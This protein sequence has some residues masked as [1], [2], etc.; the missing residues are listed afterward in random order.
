MP[1]A[2]AHS[3]SE[4]STKLK[5]KNADQ[6]DDEQSE[7]EYEI[8]EVMDA[9]RGVFPDGQMGYF[10][11]WK[12]Y[13]PDENS[14]VVEGDAENAKDLVDEFWRKNPAKRRD[15]RKSVDKK[16]IEKPRKSTS[17]VPV[18]DSDAEVKPKKRGR[19]SNASKPAESDDMQ[20]DRPEPA[21]KRKKVQ[22]PKKARSETPE[23]PVKLI[24][25][26]D[27]YKNLADWEG[28]VATVDTVEQA[29]NNTLQV[30]FTFRALISNQRN[31]G[32]SVVENSAVCYKRFPQTMLMFFQSN[33]KWKTV[34]ED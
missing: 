1:R 19:K 28:L 7:E 22:T 29:P 15:T 26:M 6:E 23:A 17:V 4:D 18:D 9:K 10:V 5:T 27:K 33:L 34:D 30:Y 24:G 2:A 3:D 13:G 12:G 16:T 8:E 21:A 20:V 31:S 11:K 32:E 25:N 14:W